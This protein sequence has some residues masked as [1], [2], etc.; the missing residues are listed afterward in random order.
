MKHLLIIGARGYGRE[1]Y[2]LFMDCKNQLKDVECIGFLDDKKD[3]LD[4]F[5]G[6]PPII[7]SVEKYE[8]KDND[9]FICALGD[10]K[11]KK[12]YVDIIKDKGGEFITLIH[13]TALITRNTSIGKGC[14]VG[15]YTY[16]SCDITIGDHCSI[17]VFSAI[18]H[19]V[20]IG[21]YNHLGAYTFMGGGS[22]IGDCVTLHPRSN[23]H[24]RKKVGDKAIVGAGSVVIRNVSSGSTVYGNP[25]KK[26]Q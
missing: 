9:V 7:S 20:K 15:R 13:P 1:T 21:E 6:Y 26:L 3:A 18:G 11:W 4:S 19:D 22:E 10:P 17:G 2:N 5:E 8:P 14:I 23:I 25:A 12:H 24:P 16:I